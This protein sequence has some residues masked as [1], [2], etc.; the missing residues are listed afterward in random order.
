MFEP[1]VSIITKKNTPFPIASFFFC[2]FEKASR[3]LLSHV[4]A[5]GSL[6]ANDTTFTSLNSWKAVI[7]GEVGHHPTDVFLLQKVVFREC[8]IK[9]TQKFWHCTWTAAERREHWGLIH[10]RDAWR[11]AK[12]HGGDFNA[13]PQHGHAQ[14]LIRNPPIAGCFPSVSKDLIW[15]NIYPQRPIITFFFLY[16]LIL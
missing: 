1:T 12:W 7:T 10:S 11:I 13:L 5:W 2:I 6:V 15:N 3:R 14:L 16:S 8:F 4:D 9:L